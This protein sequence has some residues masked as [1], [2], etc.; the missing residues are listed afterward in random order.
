MTEDL[1]R[2]VFTH[3]LLK[4]VNDKIIAW[5]MQPLAGKGLYYKSH[6][7]SIAWLEKYILTSNENTLEAG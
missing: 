6:S 1:Q 5:D 3:S 2:E 7:R 4:D